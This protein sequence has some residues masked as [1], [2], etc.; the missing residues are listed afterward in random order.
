MH[1]LK[2]RYYLESLPK[3][4]VLSLQKCWPDPLL[5]R[6]LHL[7]K[8]LEGKGKKLQREHKLRRIFFLSDILSEQSYIFTEG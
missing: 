2:L 6:T 1:H 3:V 4:N 8:F 7:F 5:T